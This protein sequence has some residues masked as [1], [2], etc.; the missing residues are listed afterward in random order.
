MTQMTAREKTLATFVGILIVALLTFTLGRF[1]LR[2][3]R[4]LKNQLASKAAELGAMQALMTERDVWVERDAWM[5]GKQP[6]LEKPGGAGVA[7]L[8]ETKKVADSHSVQIKDQVIG[9]PENRPPNYQSVA[10]QFKTTSTWSDLVD[11][12]KEMQAPERFIVFEKGGV[13]LEA[14]KAKFEGD[15]RVAKW[16][17]VSDSAAPAIR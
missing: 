5:A 3:H 11:F 12:L 17:S 6:R 15:F 13:K 9:T 1:F 8:E 7:L 16:F 14:D 4:E 2:H 10:V